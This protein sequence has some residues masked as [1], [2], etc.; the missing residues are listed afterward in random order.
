MSFPSQVD[1]VLLTPYCHLHICPKLNG[2]HFIVLETHFV[3]LAGRTLFHYL[4]YFYSLKVFGMGVTKY[5]HTISEITVKKN[6]TNSGLSEEKG[7]AVPPSP[8]HTPQSNKSWPLSTRFDSAP[9]RSQRKGEVLMMIESSLSYNST[10]IS[11]DKN[12]RHLVHRSL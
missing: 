1:V 6:I 4:N 11:N 2:H 12:K 7:T 3:I 10:L 8:P 5:T 9:S